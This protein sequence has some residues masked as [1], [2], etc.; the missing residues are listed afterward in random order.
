MLPDTLPLIGNEYGD[1]LC[2]RVDEDNRFGELVHWYHG[3]GDW[4]PVGKSIAE[5]VLH[6]IVDQFRPRKGQVLRGSSRKHCSRAPQP[7]H[8]TDKR[9]APP[10]LDAELLTGISEQ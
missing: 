8:S 6:D 4:I 9:R 5:A 1:W 3:G 2:V 7:S 10:E